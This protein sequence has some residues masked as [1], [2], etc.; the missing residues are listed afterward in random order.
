MEQRAPKGGGG[1]GG[2]G[3]D[4]VLIGDPM[5]M[6]VHKFDATTSKYVFAFLA[7]VATDYGCGLLN[8]GAGYKS[9]GHRLE[10]GKTPHILWTG[11]T[12]KYGDKYPFVFS[13]W[14]T[15]SQN[16]KIMMNAGC[17]EG[18]DRYG[19]YRIGYPQWVAT[20][21][22]QA[23]PGKKD[24]DDVKKGDIFRLKIISGSDVYDID[25]SMYNGEPGTLP[26]LMTPNK[27][28]ANYAVSFTD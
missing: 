9:K 18:I 1:G 2:G 16:K 5:H 6:K 20:F 8:F 11:D 23:L 21:Y 7:D 24:G 12:L 25:Y 17:A 3:G 15:D 13:I 14:E 4:S 10:L 22:A 28:N 19:T 27:G 26:L